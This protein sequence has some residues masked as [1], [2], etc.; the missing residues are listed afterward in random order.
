MAKKRQNWR[1]YNQSELLAK[2]ISIRLKIPLIKIL[3]R[4]RHT[5]PQARQ[6]SS[7][8]EKNVKAAFDLI[9]FDRKL[10]QNI[11]LF[12]D[13]IT[14]GATMMEAAKPI[15]GKNIVGMCFASALN[16]RH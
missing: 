16:P 15:H 12:D 5:N 10:P 7:Q 14:T 2:A 4:I 11:I 6:K 8:R 1:G 3:K 13:V 9:S